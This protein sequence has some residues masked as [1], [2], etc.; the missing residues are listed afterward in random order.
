M[1]DTNNVIGVGDRFAGTGAQ[2]CDVAA[3]NVLRE[4]IS[5]NRRVSLPIVFTWSAL[6]PI[7]VLLAAGTV[8]IERLI[9]KGVV[10]LSLRVGSKRKSTYS[11]IIVPNCVCKERATPYCIVTASS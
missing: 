1:A 2:R 8:I 6:S 5:T 3:G 10:G 11:I 7:A 4:R 9:T